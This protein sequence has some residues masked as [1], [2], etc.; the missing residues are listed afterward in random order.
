LNDFDSA[1]LWNRRYGSKSAPPPRGLIRQYEEAL[2]QHQEATFNFVSAE[3]GL[4]ETFCE[5]ARNTRDRETRER[6]IANAER[7]YSAALY[8]S[9]RVTGSESEIT[10]IREKL[11]KVSRMLDESSLLM[12]P[13]TED[14][15]IG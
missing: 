4:A 5:F 2:K 8:F 12:F 10:I 15:K 14:R 13:S 6:N 9:E 7:A 11:A 1:F 3:L